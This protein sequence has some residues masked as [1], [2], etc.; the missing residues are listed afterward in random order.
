MVVHRASELPKAK[1]QKRG[2]DGDAAKSLVFF[3]SR[4]ASVL[5]VL[6]GDAWLRSALGVL[7]E[8]CEVAVSGREGGE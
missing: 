4:N 5:C 7:R 3:L 2:Q 8:S 1:R 6:L